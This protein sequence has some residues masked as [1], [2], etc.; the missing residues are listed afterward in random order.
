VVLLLGVI[1]TAPPA[2]ATTYTPVSDEALVE[3]A[4][5]IGTF[6]VLSSDLAPAHRLTTEYQVRLETLLKGDLRGSTALVRIPGGEA[7]A[8]GL[9]FSG[10]PS[11]RPGERVLLFLVP[12]TDGTWGI[13]HLLLGAF[14]QIERADGDL[15][16]RPHL[17]EARSVDRSGQP[18]AG[19]G[20]TAR[21]R[22]AF[23]DWIA[24]RAAGRARAADYLVPVDAAALAPRFIVFRDPES[25]NQLRWFDFDQGGAVVWHA[26]SAGPT[27]YADGGVD[28]VRAGLEAW[29]GLTQS[30]INLQYGGKAPGDLGFEESDGVNTV[31]FEDP[32][33]EIEEAFDCS[34]GGV[35]AIGGPYYVTQNFRYKKQNWYPIIEGVVITNSNLSCF[36]RGNTN[37]LAE[38]LG[39]ELGHT[40]GLGH[41]CDNRAETASPDCSSSAV[42]DDALMRATV[43]NDNRG[44]RLGADDVAAG[45]ALYGEAGEPLPRTPVKLTVQ[46]VNDDA[47]LQWN[48]RSNNEQG[49]RVYRRM[50]NGAFAVAGQTAAGQATFL[51]ANLPFGTYDYEVRAWNTTGESG[52]SNRVSITV[53]ALDPGTAAFTDTV[54]YGSEDDGTAVVELERVG[55]KSGPLSVRLRTHDLSAS[56]PFDYAAKNVVVTW[57]NLDDLPK[58]VAVTIVDDFAAEGAEVLELLLETVPASGQTATTLGT[59]AV[60]VADDDGSP[61]CA[62]ADSTLCLLGGRF[63]VEVEWRNQR[64]G[65]RGT[66]HA[67]PGSDQSG[68][69]W[70]FQ[71][72]NVEL[73]VK[74]IDGRANNGAH[75]LFYGALSD[76]EY[77]VTVT[78]TATGER[79]L[80]HNPPGGICG[81]GDTRAFPQ[82]GAAGAA[83]APIDDRAAGADSTSWL[84]PAPP[85]LTRRAVC[86]PD[87]TTLCLLGGRFQVE[88]DWRNHRN[89]ATG[90]GTAIPFSDQ[91]GFFWFFDTVNIELVVK[92]LDGR[93]N[94]GK[95]W[96][97]YGALSDVEYT[98]HVTDTATAAEHSYSN[99]GGNICGAGDT[100]AFPGD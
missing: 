59:A 63:K 51:D 8:E 94:N 66:G 31:L 19:D 21:D 5:V 15:L 48:D 71:S 79:K 78:D 32:H 81:V 52:S 80:Y 42:L 20:S 75:W 97:F 29:N 35:V 99:A 17:H 33:Q 83:T 95:F 85:A 92:S 39:H 36:L 69:F 82:A 38:V 55:G 43:H 11:F 62:T 27:G 34:E 68:Y 41:S 60:A 28:A 86:V 18:V 89:G 45:R 72:E 70:F 87:A 84:L 40:L 93:G 56:A 13:A 58:F 61:G 9:R 65:A 25:Q 74:A 7:R 77:W 100:A 46:L 57:A 96:F 16:V 26:A 47:T 6:E 2:V 50:G 90:V 23:L 1:G 37:R 49:F 76:V 67:L 4:A 3:R 14:H 53:G 54:F 98:I 64:T 30:T 73:I 22:S 44:A 91:T 24:D 12:R 10:L 88:V